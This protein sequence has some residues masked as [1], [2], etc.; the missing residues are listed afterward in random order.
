MDRKQ[1]RKKEREEKM[2]GTSYINPMWIKKK[3]NNNNK[4]AH[5]VN[6]SMVKNYIYLFNME[7]VFGENKQVI[8]VFV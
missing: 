1:E 2:V 8:C 6:T 5:T 7:M 3:P 4:I